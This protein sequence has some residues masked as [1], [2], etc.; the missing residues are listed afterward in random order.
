MSCAGMRRAPRNTCSLSLSPALSPTRV[1]VVFRVFPWF[2]VAPR[3]SPAAPGIP[4]DFPGFPE[5]V[6]DCFGRPYWH[7]W[8]A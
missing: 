5:R 7:V 1:F 6:G 8:A 2:P 3:G 4:R